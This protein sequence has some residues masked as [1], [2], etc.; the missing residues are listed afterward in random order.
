MPTDTTAF[1]TGALRTLEAFARGDDGYLTPDATAEASAP[2]GRL[3]AAG[4]AALMAD[5]RRAMPDLERRDDI[6]LAGDNRDDARWTGPRAAYLVATVGAYVGTFRTPFA[7]IPPTH[8]VVSLT[9]GEAHEIV[10]G[11]ITR[12]YL[13]W[14][15]AGLMMQAACWPM[16]A[17]TGRAGIWPGPKGGHGLRLEP[18]ADAGSLDRVL[19]MHDALHRFDGR[20]LDSMPMDAWA[21][22]FMYYAAG[23]IGA[24]R[25]LDGFRAHHQI[26]F[27]RAFPDRK[28]AGHFVRL[29]D[30]PFAVTGGDVAITHTGGD[31]WGI[32]ASGKRLTMRVMDFYRFDDADKIAENWLPNDTIG[33][34]GQMGVDVMARMRH[35]TGQ[36]ATTL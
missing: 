2:F 28:G 24:C 15:I 36:P 17:T 25:G 6:L 21:D 31:Y 19:A 34:M 8:D 23:A 20:D 35:M 14:D 1:R 32:G 5:L 11:R 10:D 9:Y 13:L 27:L 22:D 12:S 18:S 16:A 33:L 26:P 7:G 4:Y 3:T 29:S 30:G